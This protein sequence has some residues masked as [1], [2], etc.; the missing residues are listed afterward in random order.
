MRALT[1]SVW[2]AS[3]PHCNHHCDTQVAPPPLIGR[4]NLRM[5]THLLLSTGH[6]TKAKVCKNGAHVHFAP[7][8]DFQKLREIAQHAM[9]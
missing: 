9:G 6:T 1:F 3:S 4:S 2:R 8:V 7:N 5:F